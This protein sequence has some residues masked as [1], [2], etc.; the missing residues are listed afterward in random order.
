MNSSVKAFIN[1]FKDMERK[2][3]PYIYVFIDLHSTLIKPNYQYGNIPTEMYDGA[4]EGLKILHE[5]KDVKIIMYTC[6][7]P[8]EIDEYIKFFYDLGIKW[9]YINENPEVI[10]NLDCYGCYDKKPY[11]NVLMDD[12]AGFDAEN[13]WVEL[14]EYLRHKYAKAS[15]HHWFEI[16]VE[17][18]FKNNYNT[19]VAS[20]SGVDETKWNEFFTDTDFRS[21][22][23]TYGEFLKKLKV[24]GKEKMLILSP[25]KPFFDKLA[26]IKK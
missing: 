13:D 14:N 23:I 7:H 9:D 20:I 10:T 21:T 24:A 4:L 2:Q 18:I 8:H 15:S 22:P 12:K 11:Y 25:A 1:A 17:R 16:V 5:A 19:M 3:W 26:Q 6:S